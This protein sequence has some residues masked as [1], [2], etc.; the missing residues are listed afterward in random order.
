MRIFFLGKFQ[1][2]DRARSAALQKAYKGHRVYDLSNFYFP[3][4]IT[5]FDIRLHNYTACVYI[6][7]NGKFQP[8]G[9]ISWKNFKVRTARDRQL[10]KGPTRATRAMISLIFTFRIARDQ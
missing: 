6:A 5:Q 7:W 9:F 8:C 2:A 4:V 10:Y 1:R 3:S